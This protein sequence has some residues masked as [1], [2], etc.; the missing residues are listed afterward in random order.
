MW[1]FRRKEELEIKS[2]EVEA[3]KL[4]SPINFVHLPVSRCSSS[5]L[6]CF[7]SA[8]GSLYWLAMHDYMC[9]SEQYSLW[10]VIHSVTVKAHDFSVHEGSVEI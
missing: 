7:G 10:I 9:M 5:V 3:F 8:V 2:F 6:A 4:C 1:S